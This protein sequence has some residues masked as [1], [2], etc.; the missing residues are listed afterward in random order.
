MTISLFVIQVAKSFNFNPIGI[1]FET[2]IFLE[3]QRAIAAVL[4][5]EKL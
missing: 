5:K 2:K 4:R 1:G 3:L